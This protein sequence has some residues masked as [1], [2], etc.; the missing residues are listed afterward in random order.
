MS[1]S[2]IG[3]PGITRLSPSSFSRTNNFLRTLSAGVP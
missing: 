1:R 2:S 3:T